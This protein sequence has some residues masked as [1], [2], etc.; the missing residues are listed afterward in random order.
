MTNILQKFKPITTLVFDIDGVFTDN[1]LLV[2]EQGELL[3]RMNAR[4]GYAVKKALQ[5]G[6]HIVLITG[7]TSE[8]VTLRF[9]KLGVQ[10]IYSGIENK[11]VVL[12]QF[13]NTHQLQIAEILYMG[14]DLL[15][16]APM[17]MV[18]LA[19]CPADAVPEVL[20][21]AQ[22]V[23][24]YKGGEGCVRDVIEKVLK[25]QNKWLLTEQI[26]VYA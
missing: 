7:G 5:E 24:P 4:D 3:R 19:T 11:A 6:L 14:D 10:H 2:T 1:G 18:G 20:A 26:D 23:S 25:L 13:I 22:Y 17:M 16:A 15:D 12:Q 21:V 8:G 9:Q